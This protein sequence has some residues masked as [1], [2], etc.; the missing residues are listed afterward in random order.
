MITTTHGA[1]A[2]N[3][4]Y[5]PELYFN[6][7]LIDAEH[8]APYSDT[9]APKVFGNVSPFDPQLFSRI[10]DFADELL[11]EKRSGKYSPIE[12]A[13]WIED[14]AAE[15][16]NKLAKAEAQAKGKNRPEY[17]RLS[18]DIAIQA[19]LGRFFAAK[20]RSGVLYRTYEQTNDRTALEESL[21]AY[22]RARA[23]WAEFANRAKGVYMADITVGELPQ[24]HGHWLDR[25]PAMDADIAALAG[26]L[27]QAKAGQPQPRVEAAIQAALE[28]PQ[29]SVPPCRHAPAPRFRPGQPLEI[30]LA[31]EPKAAAVILFYRHV[32]QAERY[33]SAE[34][35]ESGA[36]YQAT[37]PGSYTDSQYPLQYYFEIRHAPH[38]AA[39]YPGFSADL[40]NQP[41]FVVRRA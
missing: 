12:V 33:Q 27:E 24:L 15:A 37:I 39:L 32:D 14:Y 31:V 2:A 19:G 13:Q 36:T 34:M 17:R 41:Y 29:R 38:A 40:T 7:S 5:W 35:Q 8:S 23:V 26:K 3:N 30:I 10:N 4:N 1:S 11:S 21:N 6:Q 22:R 16:T 18:V 25:L 28:R 20:L 9:P